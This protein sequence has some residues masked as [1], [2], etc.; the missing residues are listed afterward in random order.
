MG[1]PFSVAISVTRFCLGTI[2]QRQLMSFA[3]DNASDGGEAYWSMYSTL[4][5]SE[6]VC[7]RSRDIVD[8]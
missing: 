7:A 3:L 1:R 6:W 5:R 4:L 8:R 2:S